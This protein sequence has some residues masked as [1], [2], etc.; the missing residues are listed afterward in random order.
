M[1]SHYFHCELENSPSSSS[2]DLWRTFQTTFLLKLHSADFAHQFDKKLMETPH[3]GLGRSGNPGQTVVNRKSYLSTQEQR[4]LRE[5]AL[6]VT[7]L[8][9]GLEVGEEE[10]EAA[11]KEDV[12]GDANETDDLDDASSIEDLEVDSEFF[13]TALSDS[14][15]LK[16]DSEEL[17]SP[18]Y[19]ATDKPNYGKIANPTLEPK[20]K[21]F[22]SE[23]K[24]TVD[25]EALRLHSAK[26]VLRQ[27]VATTLR[28]AGREKNTPI[29][30]EFLSLSL[31][32]DRLSASKEEQKVFFSKVES[33]IRSKGLHHS[34]N[35][36]K[37]NVSRCGPE[38]DFYT[39][40]SKDD[41]ILRQKIARNASM[42][43]AKEKVTILEK[44]KLRRIHEKN[45]RR[46]MAIHNKVD[47]RRVEAV[48][49]DWLVLIK[50]G[51]FMQG[52]VPRFKKVK[53]KAK[54]NVR[55]QQLAQRII[56]MWQSK[57]APEKGAKYRKCVKKLRN[58]I[59]DKTKQWKTMQ[60]LR[61]VDTLKQFLEDHK[62]ANLP[63]IVANFIHSVKV[64]SWTTVSGLRSRMYLASDILIAWL[65]AIENPTFSVFSMSLT[66]GNL[67]FTISV[68]PSTEILSTT[69]T[70]ITSF[71]PET[72]K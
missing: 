68:V 66:Q 19:R 21:L 34:V 50:L 53:E 14:N 28:T 37:K 41:R 63:I 42:S 25:P 51:A 5:S 32:L 17:H 3:I 49:V 33:I 4:L 15:L 26:S 43:S 65:F 8:G 58:F 48:T 44:E 55:E 47:K 30:R 9:L 46:E 35:L 52:V 60:K 70:S 67:V 27:S 56:G 29:P 61:A 7:Q 12:N 24:P 38:S 45:L 72:S 39:N 11:Q 57:R 36:V 16:E 6:D 31:L 54:V 1:P 69:H 64:S 40:A 22:L 23:F 62:R 2:S 18:S 71:L 10:L 59:K 20:R 13:M